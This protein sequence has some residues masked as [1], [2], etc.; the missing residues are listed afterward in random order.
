M[1]AELQY[2][3]LYTL[4]IGNKPLSSIRLYP[5]RKSLEVTIEVI[6]VVVFEKTTPKNYLSLSVTFTCLCQW[7]APPVSLSD[8]LHLSLSGTWLHTAPF[9]EKL[10]KDLVIIVASNILKANM[11]AAVLQYINDHFWVFWHMGV[12]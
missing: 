6:G 12:K 4:L 10:F 2:S 11:V 9:G 7:H 8:M 1:M 5:H 3:F